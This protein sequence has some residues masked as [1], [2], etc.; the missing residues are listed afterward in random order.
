MN[1]L[2]EDNRKEIHDALVQLHIS[3]RDAQ[4]LILEINDTLEMNRTNLD[5][6]LENIRIT[7]ENLKQFT[8][9]IKQR[10]FS[11]VR[12]KTEKDRVP[13]TGK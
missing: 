6:T 11:L 2:V 9:T 4:N 12:V 10:P 7:S 1:G 5:E 8:N 13:P 3:L